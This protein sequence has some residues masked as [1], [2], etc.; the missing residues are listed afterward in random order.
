MLLAMALLI[1]MLVSS[2]VFNDTLKNQRGYLEGLLSGIFAP[3]VALEA[4]L[5]AMAATSKVAL[6]VERLLGPVIVL[7]LTALIYCFGDPDV[8]FNEQTALVFTSLVIAMGIITYLHEGGEA[9]ALHRRFGVPAAVRLFPFALLI[10]IMFTVISRLVQFEAPVMFGFVAT[11]TVLTAA[12][13]DS[14]KEGTAVLLSSVALLVLS[15]ASWALLS[16]LSALSDGTNWWTSIPHATAVLIFVGGIEGLLFLLV[17][18]SFTQG[19]TVFKWY[20]LWWVVI[21]GV[22][23]FFFCWVILNPQA[24]AFNALVERRVIFICALVAGYALVA[25]LFWLFFRVRPGRATAAS[26]A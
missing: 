14:R 25:F 7:S 6:V 23:A 26:E 16:P 4:G 13:I 1:T 21:V 20:K 2:S 17:P 8:G 9:L 11:A 12:S 3:I 15:V 10:A 18:F 22:S 19:G 24:E 5:A